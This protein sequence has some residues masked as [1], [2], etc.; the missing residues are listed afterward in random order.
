MAQANRLRRSELARAYA[1]LRAPMQTLTV[2]RR[3]RIEHIMDGCARS[4]AEQMRARR[5][6]MDRTCA[7]IDAM[8]PNRV[9]DRGYAYVAVQKNIVAS[10]GA[11]KRGDAISVQMRDGKI[12]AQ[13]TDIEMKERPKHEKENHL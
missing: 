3:D 2:G 6:R 13:I 11:L 5:S 9:L 4:I 8:N 10:A 12:N 1:S 7:M